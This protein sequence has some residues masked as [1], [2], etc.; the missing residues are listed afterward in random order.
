MKFA[1]SLA[2]IGSRGCVLRS[3]R[4]YPKYVDDRGHAAG[5][6]PAQRVQDDEEL[7]VVVVHRRARG[8]DHEHVVPAHRVLDLDVDL[9]VREMAEPRIGQLDVGISAILAARIG[10]A[11][12]R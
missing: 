2:E 9:A 7:H 3:L 1:I 6:A 8:L 10:L 4:A 11:P 5:R 12:P